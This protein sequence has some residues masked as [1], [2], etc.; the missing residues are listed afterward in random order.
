[1]KQMHAS[2]EA[3]EEVNHLV[4]A[5]RGLQRF[6]EAESGSSG[7]PVTRWDEVKCIQVKNVGLDTFDRDVAGSAGKRGAKSW[8][9]D[10]QYITEAPGEV[11]LCCI[12]VHNVCNQSKSRSPDLERRLRFLSLRR[13]E[14]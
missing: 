11:G 2:G 12:A 3:E 7:A 5:C 13:S 6:P 10:R 14:R 4:L 1:M 9:A 8:P